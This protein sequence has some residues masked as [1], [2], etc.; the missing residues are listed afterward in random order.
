[1]KV[2]ADD[3]IDAIQKLMFCVGGEEKIV[4]KG[5]NGGYQHFLLFLEC[6]QELS[7]SKS[8]KVRLCV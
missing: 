7:F 6:F 3:K 4:E 5:E 1:M 2:F 8:F